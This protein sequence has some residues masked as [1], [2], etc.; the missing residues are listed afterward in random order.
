MFR[1][2]YLI[3]MIK[4]L[5]AF[6]LLDFAM[7]AVILYRRSVILSQIE[8]VREKLKGIFFGEMVCNLVV[9]DRSRLLLDQKEVPLN[10]II[11]LSEKKAEIKAVSDFIDSLDCMNIRLNQISHENIRPALRDVGQRIE[12]LI[13]SD[14]FAPENLSE[15]QLKILA[16]AQSILSQIGPLLNTALKSDLKK[17]NVSASYVHIRMKHIDVFY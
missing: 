8:Q 7:V 14:A 12:L 13:S 9:L 15:N 2:Q 17:L 10:E 3:N 6:I 5:V 4:Y 1:N 16:E 11:L